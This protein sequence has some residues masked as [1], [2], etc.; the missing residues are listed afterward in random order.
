MSTHRLRVFFASIAAV[1]SLLVACSGGS[2]AG[3]SGSA[4]GGPGA[5]G[6]AATPE[7][8]SPG[9]GFGCCELYAKPSVCTLRLGRAKKSADDNCIDGYD[10]VN[11]NPDAPGW[12]Q[13][14]DMDGC[15]VWTPPPDAPKICCGC[16]DAGVRPVDAGD[17]GD[18]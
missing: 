13:V 9:I 8:D 4:L 15:P 5:T 3:T 6:A 11:P 16:P 17:A 12:T 7:N 10:G 14:N 2:S 1:G 18:R